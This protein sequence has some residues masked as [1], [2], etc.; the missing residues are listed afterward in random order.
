MIDS[1][2]RT[3]RPP[4]PA[5]RGKRVVK[6]SGEESEVSGLDI[7]SSDDEAG[8]VDGTRAVIPVAD[9]DDEDDDAPLILRRSSVPAAAATGAAAAS[10]AP[11]VA[12]TTRAPTAPPKRGLFREFEFKLNPPKDGTLSGAGKWGRADSPPAA[13][14]KRTRLRAGM[15]AGSAAIAPTADPI[16]VEEEPAAVPTVPA[17]GAG[18]VVVDLG[19]DAE[20][21]PSSVAAPAVASEVQ[22]GS[23]SR[24]VQT[25]FADPAVAPQEAPPVRETASPPSP[26]PVGAGV[27]EVAAGE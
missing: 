10:A 11:G 4:P 21:A 20:G 7:P 22:P 5:P 8:R 1:P 12:A 2:A 6:E 14:S 19:S 27:E 26:Q 16:P 3:P 25:G 18:A 24:A 23:A 17:A 15:C 13:P 9:E